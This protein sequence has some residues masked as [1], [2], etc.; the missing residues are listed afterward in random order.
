[1][2]KP[3]RGKVRLRARL[4]L[5]FGLGALLLSTLL[6]AV[7]YGLVRETLLESRE[8]NAFSV[9]LNNATQVQRRVK[10]GDDEAT[11]RAV[12]TSFRGFASS[13]SVLRVGVNWY[14]ANPESFVA[15]NIKTEL[16]DAVM[17]PSEGPAQMRYRL[18]N[19]QPF[20]V[21]GLPIEGLT[22]TSYFEAVPLDDIEDTLRSVGLALL[23]AAAVST[24]AGV[25]TGA[26]AARRVLLPLEEVSQTAEAIAAGD[27]TA[28]LEVGQDRD[29]APIAASFNEM[30]ANL[31][32]RIQ[33]DAQ[34]ASNVSHELRSPLMTI[35][36]SVEVLKGRANELSEK[37]Q[38][39]LGL[40][41]GDL[42]R[43]R[44]LVEDLLEISRYDTAGGALDLDHL[45]LIE[46]VTRVAEQIDH[47]GV[48]VVYEPGIED[49]VVEV[50]KRRL[51][52]VVTNLL[53]NAR[54]YAGG[55]TDI[56]VRQVGTG[57]EIAVQDAGPGVP[58]S[59]RQAIFGR[60]SRGA[61]G[62]RRGYGTGTGLG[63]ALVAEHVRMHGG[64]VRVDD[65]PDGNPGACFV[66]ELPGVVR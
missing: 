61:E 2:V 38:T 1:M 57:I 64:R 19:N 59:E 7:T 65:R 32:E 51:A 60:F 6:A 18:P 17:D 37:G 12:L 30:A 54:N 50:D 33:R 48:P 66:V 23:G 52:R 55:A 4:T 36:A 47:A 27:L 62:G 24:L 22:R 3:T 5:A 41:D 11:V 44:Q 25:G 43:F 21:I 40:L 8:S 13:T 29:L 46:F 16:A 56:E 15:A 10:D 42:E 34:F 35:M 31:E 63:L 58:P 14:S 9:A 45:L 49:L 20:L 39:A 53:Q 28:R 26:W